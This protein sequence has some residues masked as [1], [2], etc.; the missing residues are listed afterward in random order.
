MVEN[1]LQSLN[2][3][4]S[5]LDGR[6]RLMVVIATLAMFAA[7]LFLARGAGDKDMSLLF[8]GWKQVQ[9]GM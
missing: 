3:V 4:W 2:S 8:G 7:V 9:Q 1:Q 6:R 5:S